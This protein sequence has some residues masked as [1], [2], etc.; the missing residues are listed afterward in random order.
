MI[1][2][3]FTFYK[4]QVKELEEGE[5]D[6][7]FT[8]ATACPDSFYPINKNYARAKT[9]RGMMRMGKMAEGG[10]FLHVFDHTDLNTNNWAQ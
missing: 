2:K 4:S 1:D 6:D 10:T 3:R 7:I 9:Y 8:Y 5:D